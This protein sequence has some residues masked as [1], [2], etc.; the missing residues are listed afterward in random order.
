MTDEEAG[1]LARAEAQAEKWRDMLRG[2]QRYICMLDEAFP[3][4][5]G[6]EHDVL[7]PAYRQRIDELRRRAEIAEARVREL[8]DLTGELRREAKE[9]FHVGRLLG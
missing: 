7:V 1:K 4:V 9:A 3:D 8:E 6:D 5:G 2:S